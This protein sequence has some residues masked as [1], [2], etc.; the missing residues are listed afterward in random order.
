MSALELRRGEQLVCGRLEQRAI[1]LLACHHPGEEGERHL[2]VI[3][4]ALEQLPAEVEQLAQ[5][6]GEHRGNQLVLVPE[7]AEQ[8]AAADARGRRLSLQR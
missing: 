7:V 4:I 3:R 2:G 5:A 1:L 6:L 8:R